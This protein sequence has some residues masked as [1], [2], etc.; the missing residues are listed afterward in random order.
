[1]QMHYQLYDDSDTS[2]MGSLQ[3]TLG[4]KSPSNQGWLLNMKLTTAHHT[5]KLSKKLFVF[6]KS[7]QFHSGG[8]FGV[9]LE[10]MKMRNKRNLLLHKKIDLSEEE[11]EQ[12]KKARSKICS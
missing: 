7:H 2:K 4:C 5:R 3:S 11:R 9:G 6:C 10:R 8:G 12:R 1:M